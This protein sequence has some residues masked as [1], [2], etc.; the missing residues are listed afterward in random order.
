[1]GADLYKHKPKALK[2][3]ICNTADTMS[4]YLVILFLNWTVRFYNIMAYKLCAES[5][6]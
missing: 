2:V 1:M 4:K 3:S 6:Y 5:K